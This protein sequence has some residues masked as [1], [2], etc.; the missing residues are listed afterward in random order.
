MPKGSAVMAIREKDLWKGFFNFRTSADNGSALFAHCIGL[1]HDTCDKYGIPFDLY[2]DDF[3]TG[4]FIPTD[5][6]KCAVIFNPDSP[7]GSLCYC[8]LITDTAYSTLVQGWRLYN[9]SNVN[10]PRSKD[11]SL[12]SIGTAIFGNKADQEW[13]AIMD[14]VFEDINRQIQ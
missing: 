13:N 6:G 8:I 5:A 1:L 7:K 4:K 12:K 2:Y 10:P 14:R 11:I 9:T 3:A